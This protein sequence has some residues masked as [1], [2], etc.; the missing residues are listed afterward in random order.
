VLGQKVVVLN[1]GNA[2][3]DIGQ[4]TLGGSNPDQF[5]QPVVMDLCSGVTVPAGGSCTVKIQFKPKAAGPMSATLVIPSTASNESVATVT[6]SG[7]G[8]P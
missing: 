4:I 1:S 6:L 5:R 7:T 3:L 8:T 2:D